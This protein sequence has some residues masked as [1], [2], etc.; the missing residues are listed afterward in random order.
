[1]SFSRD[2]SSDVCSSDLDGLAGGEGGQRAA[3]HHGHVGVVDAEV[4]IG[5]GHR[6][7]HGVAAVRDA[8]AVGDRLAVQ[9][10][11]VLAAGAA[12]G[13]RVVAPVDRLVQQHG[14]TDAVDRGGVVV[15]DH[16]D[17]GQRIAVAVGGDARDLGGVHQV[18][19]QGGLEVEGH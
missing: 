13:A 15:L 7:E 12:G 19:V 8:E 14:G 16:G 11:K 3:P 18:S 2:W 9:G 6:G 4:G 1:T 10:R 17:A 5:D